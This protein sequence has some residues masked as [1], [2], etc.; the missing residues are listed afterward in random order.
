VHDTLLWRHH[1]VVWCCAGRYQHSNQYLS[2][3]YSTQTGYSTVI[4]THRD[5]CRRA[6]E[7][8]VHKLLLVSQA[9]DV[10]IGHCI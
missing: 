10:E 1:S 7:L 8:C 2:V 6:I 9:T 4:G 3:L 5:S